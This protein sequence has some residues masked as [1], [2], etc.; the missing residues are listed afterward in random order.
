MWAG[1]ILNF[2]IIFITF[3]Y[4]KIITTNHKEAKT[5]DKKINKNVNICDIP[6]VNKIN[7]NNNCVDNSSVNNNC[8]V[9]NT[10]IP[11]NVHPVHSD[12]TGDLLEYNP[13]E[14]FSIGPSILQNYFEHSESIDS[15]LTSRGDSRAGRGPI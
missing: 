1:K 8:E 11:E 6:V 4:I 3:R 2:V 5:K 13:E 7:V 10:F 12:S 14:T 15:P 9:Y